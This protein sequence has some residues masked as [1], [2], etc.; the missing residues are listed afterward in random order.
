MEELLGQNGTSGQMNQGSRQA[1]TQAMAIT[2][3]KEVEKTV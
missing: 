3:H 1:L 2:V